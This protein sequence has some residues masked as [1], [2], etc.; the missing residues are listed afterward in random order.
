MFLTVTADSVSGVKMVAS[1]LTA[2]LPAEQMS[3]SRLGAL[4]TVVALPLNVGVPLT[5]GLPAGQMSPGRVG[6]QMVVT[7]PSSWVQV[8]PWWSEYQVMLHLDVLCIPG[9]NS[10]LSHRSEYGGLFYASLDLITSLYL[11]PSTM[12]LPHRIHP[13]YHAGHSLF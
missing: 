9:C 1:P 5:Q 10:P 6:V 13:L 3:P 11:L 2:G 4:R 12:V 8:E 7:L